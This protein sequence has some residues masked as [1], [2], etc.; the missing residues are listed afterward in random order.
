MSF[1]VGTLNV[2]KTVARKMSQVTFPFLWNFTWVCDKQMH[3]VGQASV[4]MLIMGLAFSVISKHII[5]HQITFIATKPFVFLHLHCN[6]IE[7]RKKLMN[8]L[9]F[10]A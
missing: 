9:V 8:F 2:I 10:G 6:E 3:S 7:R 4:I 1:F 5:S